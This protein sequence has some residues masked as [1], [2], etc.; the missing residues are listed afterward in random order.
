MCLYSTGDVCSRLALSRCCSGHNEH[1]VILFVARFFFSLF[2]SS[3]FL[4]FPS[5]TLV[6]SLATHIILEETFLSMSNSSSETIHLFDYTFFH[7][8]VVE[9]ARSRESERDKTEKHNFFGHVYSSVEI[10]KERSAI[11]SCQR[12]DRD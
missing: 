2:S 12:A 7:K 6:L 8:N 10:G 5:R 3:S 1:H 9:R 11:V 4:F